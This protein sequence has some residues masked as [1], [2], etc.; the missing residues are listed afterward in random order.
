MPHNIAITSADGQTGHLVSELLLSP[1]FASKL[2]GPLTCLSY[3][4]EKT[5][6]LEEAGA[7]VVPMP[8]AAA[9]SKTKSATTAAAKKAHASLVTSLKDAKVDAIM[10]I[11]PA[12]EAKVELTKQLVE[13]AKEAGVQN[14]L[15]LSAAGCDFA[16]PKEQPILR[17][18]IEIE[19]MVME[20]KGD[21]DVPLGHSPCILRAGLYAETLLLLAKQA[22]ADG[23]LRLPIGPTHKCAPVALGDVALCAA[24]VLTGEGKMGFHD[25]HRGQLITLTGPIMTAGDELVEAMKEAIG[26]ELKFE[27]IKPEEAKKMLTKNSDVDPSEIEYLLEIFALARKGFLNYVST[28]AFIALAGQKPQELTEFFKTYSDEFTRKRRKTGKTGSKEE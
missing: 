8:T 1:D 4:P 21:A 6:D 28:T 7:V 26:V 10:I 2:G 25:D 22:Q 18:F 15:L 17:S 23:A 16:D 20:C 14:V 3:N 11:P 9:D 27:D 12:R 24:T 5:K 13:A 19:R